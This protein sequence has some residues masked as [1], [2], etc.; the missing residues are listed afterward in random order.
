M[1]R[2]ETIE[3][4]LA[5]LLRT[6]DDL[7]EIVAA[8]ATEIARL[9]KQVDFLLE[10]EAGRGAEATGGVYLGDERPPHY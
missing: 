8:Q 3:G 7:N 5:H 9:R 2:I 10:R 4:H 6:V 1:D